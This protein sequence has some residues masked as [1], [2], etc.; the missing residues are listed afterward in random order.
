[1]GADP[2]SSP[3]DT[4]ASEDL[5]PRSIDVRGNLLLLMEELL[6]ISALVRRVIFGPSLLAGR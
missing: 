4:V 5:E 3:T 6:A 2:E 1:M